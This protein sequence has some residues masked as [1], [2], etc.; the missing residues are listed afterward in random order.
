MITT[1]E[2]SFG[3]DTDHDYREEEPRLGCN[4]RACYYA[5]ER[6]IE[7]ELRKLYEAEIDPQID[8]MISL[9]IVRQALQK[10]LYGHVTYEAM[11]TSLVEAL[12]RN[13]Q[14]NYRDQVQRATLKPVRIVI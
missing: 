11:K 10:Y 6:H 1:S 8:G 9:P 5:R 13:A 14:E 3:P 12:W 7:P 2:L 4:C